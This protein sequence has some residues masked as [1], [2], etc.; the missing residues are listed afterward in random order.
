MSDLKQITKLAEEMLKLEFSIEESMEEINAL[1]EAHRKIQEGDLPEAMEKAGMEDFTLKNG[2]RVAI[3][4]VTH[5]GISKTNEA[6]AFG[7]LRANGHE[8]LIK[9]E[10]TVKFGKGEDRKAEAVF[11]L[12]MKRRGL[13]D[14]SIIGKQAVHHSTL[15]SFVLKALE[16]GL[17][18]PHDTFGIFQRTI[19]KVGAVKR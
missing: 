11:A 17:E 18:I 14:N 7:W 4:V 3:E 2:R 1:K 10:I 6:D 13:K 16:A 19:A 8:A 15:K 5:C 12:L 9:R